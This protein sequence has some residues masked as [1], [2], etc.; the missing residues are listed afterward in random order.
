[1]TTNTL[2]FIG[3]GVMGEPMCRNMAVKSGLPMLASDL[4]PQPLQRL[5]NHGV[6][7]AASAA[8]IAARA[9]IV[10]LSLP[11]GRELEALCRGSDGLLEHS[12]RGQTIVDCSTSPVTLTRDLAAAFRQ[13]GTDYADAPIART[14]QAA[15]E[16]TLS[17]MVGA[18]R[19]VFERIEPLL[20]CC[21]SDIT[22]CGDVGCGQV[23]KLMNNMVLFQTVVALAEA[24][25]VGSRAGVDGRLLFETLSKGSADSFALRSHGMKSMLPGE[26]P[27]R[28]F[29]T[30]YASKDLSYALQLAEDLGINLAGAE[31]TRKLLT[32]T[33]RRGFGQEYYPAV[34][35]VI[36]PDYV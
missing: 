11:G 8:E 1:M 7:S 29:S 4:R 20:A 33:S 27:A 5:R 26:F 16:G 9:D 30:D 36:D 6:E 32:E 3:T 17:I 34:I 2:G 10:F 12:R 28:A 22:H 15:E 18:T 21:A 23:V 35:K 13:R 19:N 14:R 25:T 24:L 31:T